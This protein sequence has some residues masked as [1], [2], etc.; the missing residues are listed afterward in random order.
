MVM[1]TKETTMKRIA[2]MLA[3]STIF[4]Q[5]GCG[6]GGGSTGTQQKTAIITFST[7]SSAHTAPLQGIQLTTRL[8]AG[9]SV[10]NIDSALVGRNDNAIPQRVYTPNPPVVSFIVQSSISAA[11]P[12]KFGPFAAL[13]C[14]V[15]P[16]VTLDQSSFSV[17][18]GDLQMTG[19]DAGGNTIDLVQQLGPNPVRLSVTFGF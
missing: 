7:V 15:A 13:T 19:K 16:G 14:E 12:I 4:L 10:S 8:P 2:L 17:L 11:A 18:S 6:G 5:A 3:C 9:A 1:K